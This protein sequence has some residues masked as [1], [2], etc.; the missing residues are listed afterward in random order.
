MVAQRGW[1]RCGTVG[2]RVVGGSL[3][4]G[5]ASGF[6]VHFAG[7]A[8]AV[9]DALHILYADGFA[10]CS[11][12]FGKEFLH[13]ALNVVGYFLA[14]FTVAK[15]VLHVAQILLQKGVGVLVDGIQ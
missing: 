4:V 13:A 8:Y 5:L 11:L 3:G 7:V 15:I 6:V 2:A 9:H 12:E 1:R 10:P 14:A